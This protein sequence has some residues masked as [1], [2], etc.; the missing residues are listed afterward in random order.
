[1]LLQLVDL[2]RAG[3]QVRAQP[4]DLGLA[5]PETLTDGTTEGGVD[6]EVL[7]LALGEQ[8]GLAH[9]VTRELRT[10]L[11]DLLRHQHGRADSGR[12]GHASGHDEG[13]NRLHRHRG[14]DDDGGQREH[15]HCGRHAQRAGK[16]ATGHADRLGPTRH[17]IATARRGSPTNFQAE[18]EASVHFAAEQRRAFPATVADVLRSTSRGRP[19]IAVATLLALLGACGTPETSRSESQPATEGV[20]LSIGDSY[21]AG[22]RPADDGEAA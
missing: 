17:A 5:R 11:A 12:Q 21:A 13:R 20:Y 6:L 19:L 2:G 1:P 8:A 7:A 4:R 3:G 9:A 16:C 22:Y 15:E 14:D 10:H 18:P